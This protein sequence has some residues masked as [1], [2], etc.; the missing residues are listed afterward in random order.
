LRALQL[1]AKQKYLAKNA[2][3]PCI[4]RSGGFVEAD[5][6][7]ENTEREALHPI[8]Q[9]RAFAALRDKGQGED[10]IAAAFGVTPAVV[11]QRLRLAKASP[12]LIKAYEDEAITLEHLMA[13]C[14]TDDT[15]RQEQVYNAVEGH[16]NNHPD[17]IRR[18]LT[19]KTVRADDPRAVF[20]GADAYKAAG[21]IVIRDLFDEDEGG[22]LQDVALLE[23]L[24]G[25]KLE[26]EAETIRAEGWKWVECAIA[27]PWNHKRDY[28]PIKP[29]KP[30]LTD[31]EQEHYDTLANEHDELAMAEDDLSEQDQNRLNEVIARI[32][33]LDAKS[34]V[35]ETKMIAKGGVFISLGDN[36]KLVID[37]GH[38]HPDDIK[39]TRAASDLDD[40][41][42]DDE[43]FDPE[44]GEITHHP[45]QNG[46]A[47]DN[48]DS[49]PDIPDR[50]MIELTAHH[51]LALREALAND[52]GMAYLAMLHVL[53][54]RL[55]YRFHTDDTCLQVEAKHNLTSPFPGLADASYA[56]AIDARH[57]QW[58]EALPKNPK[59][60]WAM[61][62]SL[63]TDN[64]EA[65]FAH[66]AG[67]TI[68][69]VYEP[70]HR[71]SGKKAHA[72]HLATALKLDMTSAGWVTRADNYL[73]R[74][75]KTKII[76]AVR[77]AKG[78]EI[79]ALLDDL[80]KK[81]MAQEAERLLDGTGWLPE[82]LRTP[83]PL[84]E[85]PEQSLPAF[86]DGTEL[87]AA[88]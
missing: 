75:T 59:E 67:L 50:L 1:L 31:A 27:F 38:I 82:P 10:T 58:E 18:M 70:Y 71:I 28:L 42:G 48:D 41:L 85:A 55:F 2:P 15:A 7:A 11:K 84:D 4:V 57:R 9:F 32:D 73:A 26:A 24:V 14:L 69:A 16:W 19:E 65:L 83:A 40:V 80:K 39:K 87:Q 68:N 20:F 25:E 35:F 47:A 77:E 60:L 13:F 30:A 33:E 22:Y 12:V 61:I 44:T 52:P 34:P 53:T 6:L 46:N 78:D 17:A 21:G 45:G 5:S 76:E 62:A 63:D 37:R 88:E 74:V 81:E 72:L 36:G 54:L 64:R 3:V 79:A 56:K 8:D 29:K 23:R 49:G 43:A 86:L 51:S 66:C